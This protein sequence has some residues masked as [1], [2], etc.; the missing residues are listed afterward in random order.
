LIG[1]RPITN[2]YKDVCANPRKN[3][4]IFHFFFVPSPDLLDDCGSQETAGGKL[5]DLLVAVFK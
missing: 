4:S 1:F 2:L 5:L 3:T